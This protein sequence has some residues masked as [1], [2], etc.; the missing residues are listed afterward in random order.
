MNL[1]GLLTQPWPWY[2]AGPAVGLVVPLLLLLANRP[3]GLSS[4]LRH[5]CAALPM[6]GTYFDY[7]W[8][9]VGG[10][11]LLVFGGIALGGLLGGVVLGD[12]GPVRVAAST[13]A[14]LQALGV[15]QGDGLAPA[16]LFG[17]QAILA[18]PGL[19]FGLVGGILIGFGTRWAA[20]CT[21][22]HAIMGL[23]SG[24]WP[25]L[26]AVIGFFA[27]GLVTTHLVLPWLLPALL[28]GTP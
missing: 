12:P 10:W 2:V 14:H 13:Q 7:D 16:A 24:Q 17:W 28:G 19:V 1:P 4:N 25:S 21:S 9:R 22:G 26:V 3:F 20:G 23:A 27:G 11:N 5:L 8:R 18:G 15:V 6:R